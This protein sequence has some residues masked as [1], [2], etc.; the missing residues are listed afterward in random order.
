MTARA[1]SG[2]LHRRSLLSPIGARNS[3]VWVWFIVLSREASALVWACG[4][5]SKR[6]EVHLTHQH[7]LTF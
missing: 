4:D 7:E 2:W 3:T 6:I 1:R 5:A